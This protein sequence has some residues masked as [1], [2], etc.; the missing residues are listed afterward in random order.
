MKI[1]SIH[2]ALFRSPLKTP[3]K[4]ALRTVENLEDIVVIIKCDNGNIGFGEGSPTAVITGETLGTMQAA[5]SYLGPMITGLSIIDDFEEILHR[6]HARLL[7]NTTAKSAIEIAL[8][9]LKAKAYK[10]PLYKLLGGTKTSFE[11]DIT[12]SLN[13]IDQMIIDSLKAISLG[14]KI[15]KIKLGNNPIQDIDRIMAIHDAVPKDT[16]LR[17]D[18]N[19]GWNKE[20]SVRVIQTIE[21]RGIIAQCIEQPV[22]ADDIAGLKYIKER[23]QTPLLADEAVFNLA[24][25][26][27]ILESDSA[28]YINIKLAKCGGI[29][30][31]IKIAKKAREFGVSCMMGCMLEGPMGIIAALHVAS[32]ASDVITMIDL[33]AVA[34]LCAPPSDCSAVFN[35]S[36][37]ILSDESGLGIKYEI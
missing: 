8:Y 10:Q 20:E 29:S 36:H 34:L 18:A 12:I 17:L 16:I 19:Q 26:T 35:E 21:S 31:S 28:D 33:D 7:H 14:Y 13:D 3:F 25:A 1:L 9:D 24:Q 4:T 32:A 27:A 6:L 5:I 30:E 15:L 2:T 22:K 11:T 23:I 37:I